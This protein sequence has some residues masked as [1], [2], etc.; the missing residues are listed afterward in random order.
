MVT[1]LFLPTKG[2][3]A[4]SF[5]DDFRRLGG[6]EVH[7]VTADVPGAREFDSTHPN[8]VHRLSLERVSWLRPE[9]L[10]MYAKLFGKS[11]WLALTNRFA[12]VFAGRVLPEGLVAFAIARLVGRP[13]L[14]YAHGEELTGWGRGRKFRTSCFVF[15][16]ADAVLSN[17][18]FT[19]DTLVSLLGV[20]PGRVNVV[21]PTVDEE[22]FRPG[23]AADDL[24]A[25]IGVGAGQRLVLSVGRL[26]RRKGFDRVI[27]A[28]PPLR[29]RGID[30]HCA[31]IGIGEEREHLA[32]LA[33]ETGVA[34]R[35]H[36]LGHVSY[37]DLP[38]WYCACDV[39]AMPNRDIGG[40]TE[41]FGLV[42]LEAAAAA[43][44][45]VAGLSGGTG[46]AV[47]D[48]VTGLRVDGEHVDAVAGAL[49]ELLSNPL[50]AEVMGN[51]GR[52][53][54][55]DNFT[56]RRRV[57]QLLGLAQRPKRKRG[58]TLDEALQTSAGTREHRGEPPGG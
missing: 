25:S 53:R 8:T 29:A 2:G 52:Q 36:L 14:V 42:F 11:A 23:L 15:R 20:E 50:R 55:L 45:V 26:M 51:A 18:D 37:D 31:I 46:S 48:G 32:A 4:V 43:R 19:R 12:A 17:S 9:S 57:E 10:L 49:A 5:D 34:D 56:H 16:H 30:T 40:D 44:P 27:R 28:L 6:K 3:T 24:R 47:V 21:Y 22:R 1:E 39:F 13:F 33:A 35:V 38:R 7:I 58:N 41:G 54:V